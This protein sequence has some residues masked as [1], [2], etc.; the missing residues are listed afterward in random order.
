[1]IWMDIYAPMM[2]SFGSCAIRRMES[3]YVSGG[4]KEINGGG[5]DQ[6]K[7]KSPGW[8]LS[9]TRAECFGNCKRLPLCISVRDDRFG[10]PSSPKCDEKKHECVNRTRAGFGGGVIGREGLRQEQVT[11]T[12]HNMTHP[13]LRRSRR[14][15]P[16]SDWT[17]ESVLLDASYLL[18]PVGDIG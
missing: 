14:Y 11:D 18:L 2:P 3:R 9:V 1:M 5:Y 8:R 7:R 6:E 16:F 15:R 4:S 17:L 12:A 13:L 10:P